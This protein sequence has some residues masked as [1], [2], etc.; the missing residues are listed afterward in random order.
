MNCL[1]PRVSPVCGTFIQPWLY[2]KY[3]DEQFVSELTALKEAGIEYL[4]MGDVAYRESDEKSWTVYYDN[5]IEGVE[6]GQNNLDRL[7]YFCEAVGIKLYLGLGNN[8]AWWQRDLSKAE[9]SDKLNKDI[10]FSIQLAENLYDTYKVRYGETFYGFYWVYEIW[11]HFSWN[12]AASREKYADNLSNAFNKLIHKLNE[13]DEQMPLMFSPFSSASLFTASIKNTQKFYELFISK[14]DFRCIDIL[15]PMDNVGGGSLNVNTVENWHKM[16]YESVNNSGNKLI[17]MANCESFIQPK[18]N[19]LNY[20]KTDFNYWEPA[21]VKRFIRQLE[22]AGKYVQGI[23]SFSLPH[24][25]SDLN[26]PPSYLNLFKDYCINAV[27]DTILPT[28]PAEVVFETIIYREESCLKIS[29][30]GVSDNNGVAKVSVYKNNRLVDYR[31]PNIWALSYNTDFENYILDFKFSQGDIYTIR[32]TDCWGNE[33][34][35][36]EFTYQNE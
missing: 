36:V 10:D 31:L 29:W 11:N 17:L 6:T 15:C 5:A 18:N 12:N 14:N 25:Y 35:A 1:K 2:M 3:T 21:P 34:K 16:Y 33:C 30:L 26:N 19:R 24:Y 8:A 22:I 13:I 20:S 28:P 7:F 27:Q 4:V 23:F 9:D 32:V